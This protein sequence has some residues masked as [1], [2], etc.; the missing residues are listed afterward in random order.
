VIDVATLQAWVEKLGYDTVA[1]GPT[2]LRLVPRSPP[3]PPQPPFFMQVSDN[4][5]LLS[6]LPMLA[7]GAYRAEDLGRRLLMA[8]RDM[9]LAK[10]A[11]DREG[12]VVLCA[13][14]PTESLDASEVADAVTR[15]AQYAR[16]FHQ[17]FVKRR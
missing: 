9:R 13:E 15:M 3:T 6:M 16:R 14:L 17:E 5:V 11:L 1:E 8:N 12:S 7:H 4:W 2:T 10:F